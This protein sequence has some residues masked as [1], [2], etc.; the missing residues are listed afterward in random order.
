MLHE[1]VLEGRIV[2]PDGIEEAQLGIDSGRITALSKQSLRG[3]EQVD[4]R[5]CYI[6]PG[7]VDPHVHL[8]E[9]GSHHWA[10]KEDFAS[11]AAAALHGGVTTV[12][13]MPNTPEPGITAER[14][15]AKKELA[16][17]QSRGALEI[18]F[19]A[20]VT[21][22]T[23]TGLAALQPEVV[24]YKLYLVETAG[25]YLDP[26]SLP[27]ALRAVAASARPAIVHAEDQALLTQQ[28]AQEAASAD[29]RSPR[30]RDHAAL[31]PP[32]A[33]V[34]AVERVLAAAA[35]VPH[36]SLNVAHVSV[37]D[38]I[39]RIK[40]FAKV[41]C[42]VT[43]HHLFF[44]R[45]DALQRQGFLKTNPPVRT[46]ENRQRLLAA[47]KAGAID[48]LASDHAPHTREEKARDLLDAPAGVPH[49]DTYGNFVSWL[50]VNCGV[51][52]S[53]IARTCAYQPARFLGLRDRGRIE[54]GARADLTILE[55]QHPVRISRERLYT[56]CGWSPFEGFEFPGTV[57][58]TISHGAVLSEY[59]EVRLS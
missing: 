55:L 53:L 32:E 4:T 23:V 57:K 41:Q 14:I 35:N 7:F 30:S 44:T 19:C 8:R 43:P 34:V 54:V 5:G 2:N 42:E 29:D 16:R 1:L 11:G 28:R 40:R 10:Y 17:A 58:H 38:S 59:D 56:R 49:L 50:L 18:L 6:F 24:A 45:E 31:R 21:E 13:D 48:F 25:L 51:H 36:L 15:R 46:E 52:P 39:A 47:F 12:V 20:G 9:D 27:A 26:A 22:R 37:H 33:E 3:E